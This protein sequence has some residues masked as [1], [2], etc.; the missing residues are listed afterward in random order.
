[1]SR[2]EK[3]ELLRLLM[4]KEARQR[5]TLIN[6]LYPEKDTTVNGVTYFARDKY[7]K[8]LEFFRA[9]AKYK[10][11][12]ALA[13]NRV[14]KTFGIGGYE[15]T[16]HL[17]GLYPDWWQGRRFD[18][19]ISAWAAGKTS[20]TTRDIIQLTLL[21]K[22]IG[23]GTHKTVDGEGLI[24]ASTLEK[25]TWNS[26]ISDCADTV[27]V[28]HVSGGVSDLG[29]KA[30]KQGR[31]SFEGTQKQV[32]WADEEVPMDVY[33]EMLIR[34]TATDGNSADGLA[35]LTFTPLEGLTDVVMEF[36]PDMQTIG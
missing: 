16:L 19:P 15:T 24:P 17:T 9:G 34:L 36:I 4:A 23:S 20:E 11:R 27:K 10:E 26:G 21:G 32:I 1:M 30:Y 29:F 33:S 3:E 6:L 25:I 18:K 13:A 8:H 22:V 12:C 7:T 28:R 5:K 14:G 31:G 35:L 2:S